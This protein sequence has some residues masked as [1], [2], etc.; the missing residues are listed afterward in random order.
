VWMIWW[1]SNRRA[2]EDSERTI[3]ELKMILLRDLCNWMVALSNH[4]FSFVL[5]FIDTCYPL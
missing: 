5:D 2:F 4:L 3:V 1:E